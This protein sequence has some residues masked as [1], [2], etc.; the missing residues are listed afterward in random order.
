MVV[1]GPSGVGKSTVLDALRSDVEFGFSIS[2]TTRDPRPSE[3]DGVHYHFVN[4]DRFLEMIDGGELVE[5]AEYGG[6]LYG[7]PV[8]S[9]RRARAESGIVVLDIELEGAKQVRAAFPDA[10]L[11][12]IE[13]TSFEELERRLR[14]R[15][16][17]EEEA[18]LRRLSRARR[19]M[20]LAESVF[21]HILVN[22]DVVETA[23]RLRE[24]VLTG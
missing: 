8:E 21:D 13:P 1:S 18:I 6:H 22:D 2:A 4:R 10:V 20:D 12:W 9:V 15:G 7:T 16:D 17:T 3:V 19:D 5:W 24:I 14:S 11:V 23:S